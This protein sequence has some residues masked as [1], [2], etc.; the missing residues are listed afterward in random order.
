MLFEYF[1]DLHVHLGRTQDGLPVKVTGAR[2]QVL[3]NVLDEAINRKGLDVVGI[4]DAACPPV[5][6]E[7]EEMIRS[8]K[9]QELSEG[10]L[11]YFNRITVIPGV[12]IEATEENGFRAHWLAYFPFLE[13]I[14]DF[15]E[16][17][18]HY[19]T[20]PGLSTQCCPLPA[21]IL[22][23]EVVNREG[24]FLPAHAFTPHRGVYG[25]CTGSL[26][27]LLG[28]EGFE[29]IF[30]LELGLSADTDLADHLVE[31]ADITFLSNSDAHS[32]KSL[33][34]E[35]NVFL[36]A[37]PNWSEIVKSLR[38]EDRR[39][40][41]ANYG[42][43]PRLGKY[44]RT[45]CLSCRLTAIGKPPV[46]V[47]PYCESKKIVKGVLD[48][49]QEIG[50][51]TESHHPGHRPPYHYQIPLSFL[52]GVGVKTIQKLLARFGTEMTI[53]HRASQ[54]ELVQTVGTRFGELIWQARTGK[55][56]ISAGGGGFYG[57]VSC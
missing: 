2:N 54:E 12:E 55:L 47:C 57:K 33:G 46:L 38:R 4:V 24:I 50:D 49:V 6:A 31:L 22:L 32:L 1:G 23:F 52:P 48:R 43:D 42:L 19:L 30:A 11:R 5:C 35:Y 3:S 40:I 15:A 20:N 14:R 27:E 45:F 26:R 51:W 25:Q 7:L 44:H 37:E 17:L 53:L 56:T 28:K 18:S 21:R 34:R 41:T 16:F 29:L 9:V 39:M 10:G 36:L 13:K 8:G